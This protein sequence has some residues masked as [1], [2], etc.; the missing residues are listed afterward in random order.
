VSVQI[1]TK[2]ETEKKSVFAGFQD[3]KVAEKGIECDMR[4]STERIFF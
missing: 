2:S 4:Q 1:V 3:S